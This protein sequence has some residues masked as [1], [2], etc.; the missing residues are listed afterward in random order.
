MS[1]MSISAS[2]MQAAFIKA[3]QESAAS[4]C[5]LGQ[6]QNKRSWV[7]VSI[8]GARFHLKIKN[9]KVKKVTPYGQRGGWFQRI[10]GQAI[11]K[12]LLRAVKE[13][14]VSAIIETR[15]VIPTQSK[16]PLI[17]Y[18]VSSILNNTDKLSMSLIDMSIPRTPTSSIPGTPTN[19]IPGAP[20]NSM[21]TEYRY[22]SEQPPSESVSQVLY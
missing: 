1:Q 5:S 21:V 4:G 19:S 16:G 13:F 15:T 6:A 10:T 22:Q 11:E 8:N 12:R 17:E 2:Q 9:D 14:H 3:V 18:C 7:D 20:T